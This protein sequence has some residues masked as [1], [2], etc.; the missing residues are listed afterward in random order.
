M[1]TRSA[2]ILSGTGQNALGPLSQH[3]CERLTLTLALSN[4]CSSGVP[5]ACAVRVNLYTDFLRNEDAISWDPEW[6][7]T[8][9]IGKGEGR[10]DSQRKNN[11]YVL[12]CPSSSNE[13]WKSETCFRYA[14]AILLKRTVCSVLVKYS[15]APVEDKPVVWGV[16]TDRAFSRA[17]QIDNL[18]VFNG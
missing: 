2:G 3:R 10:R 18:I 15:H 4:P 11:I 17:L 16:R 1:R 12:G 5:S 13:T 14:L 7:R 6:D 9:R 8:K